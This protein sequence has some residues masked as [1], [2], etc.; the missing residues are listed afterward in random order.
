DPEAAFQPPR[1]KDVVV[2]PMDTIDLASVK[3]PVLPLAENPSGPTS[4]LAVTVPDLPASVAFVNPDNSIQVNLQR[5]PVIVAYQ[6]TNT[7]PRAGGVSAKAFITVPALGTF[8]PILRPRL[9]PLVVA[10][11]ETLSIP[12]AKYVRVG[13][14][15]QAKLIEPEKIVATKAEPGAPVV[16]RG[17]KTLLYTAEWGY[18]GPASITFGV[19][20]G[21]PANQRTRRSVLT[22]P[23]T[24]TGGK[25][26]A[27]VFTPPGLEVGIADSPRTIDLA[28]FTEVRGAV[29]SAGLVF[30]VVSQ[31]PPAFTVRLD[32]SR[33]TVAARPEAGIGA[34]GAVRLSARFNDSPVSYADVELTAVASQRRLLA[35]AQIPDQVANDGQTISVDVLAGSVDPAADIGRPRLLAASLKPE[36]T[37]SLSSS[38]STISLAF[39][40]QAT[41]TGIVSYQVNDALG[42]PARVVSGSFAVTVRGRPDPPAGLELGMVT[43]GAV[44]LTWEVPDN[45]GAPIEGYEAKAL[46]GPSKTCAGPPCVVDGL[47]NGQRYSFQVRARNAVGWSDFSA[48]SRTEVVD[49]APA[50]VPSASVTVKAGDKSL[51]VSWTGAAGPG[52]AVRSYQVAVTADREDPRN[53]E[54]RGTQTA[55]R[56][57]TN[58]VTYQVVVRAQN[59]SGMLGPPSSP[60]S[61]M[62]VGPP[63]EPTITKLERSGEGEFTI[64]WKAVDPNGDAPRYELHVS[65]RGAGG[66]FAVDGTEHVFRGAEPGYDYEFW[67]VA[68]NKGGSR[69]SAKRP[70]TMWAKPAARLKS[71]AQS[72]WTDAPEPGGAAVDSDWSET[73]QGGIRVTHEFTLAGG[74]LGA[75]LAADAPKRFEHLA[76][77]TYKATLTVCLD[78]D[79]IKEFHGDAADL[80]DSATIDSVDV[81]TV[82]SAVTGA[83]AKVVSGKIMVTG[84]HIEDTG[85][86]GEITY[87]CASQSEREWED[88]TENWCSVVSGGANP[89]DSLWLRAKNSIGEGV[90]VEVSVTPEPTPPS[91]P[92]A[93]PPAGPTAAPPSTEPAPPAARP[94]SA[95]SRLAGFPNPWWFGPPVHRSLWPC[96]A[97]P[98]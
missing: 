60:V 7:N 75:H 62:P 76:S 55:V 35:L 47:V 14:G 20:D 66:P 19:V 18:A 37:A 84:L 87:Q 63:G 79:T 61:A 70:A 23:I 30:Q 72:P 38:G 89:A 24:V 96:F 90:F 92:T 32:G 86:A 45:H 93:S 1:A 43:D 54:V 3:V 59:S 10:A 40:R 74:R 73:T 83:T 22:L 36:S 29:D 57:L 71:A 15:K 33:L 8:P 26:L 39:D 50:P 49:V 31:P 34:R 41:G 28:E 81:K 5:D 65:G 13:P 2:R 46:S 4:D 6:L 52:S 64:G 94:S 21:D 91:T 95:G 68:A 56:G 44:E 77:G 88:L 78:R 85:N 12:L 98:R 80:C 97:T 17:L 51:D 42:D 67:V 53:L 11:G 16:E 27:P 58:G 82:P 48:V 9:E 69:S 25:Q